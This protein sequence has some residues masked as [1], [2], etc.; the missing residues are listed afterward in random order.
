MTFS[1]KLQAAGFYHNVELRPNA[2]YVSEEKN[3]IERGEGGVCC[4]ESYRCVMHHDVLSS[5]LYTHVCSLRCVL[6]CVCFLFLLVVRVFVPV[7]LLFSPLASLS[8]TSTLGSAILFAH[9][10]CK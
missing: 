5:E 10:S 9:Y 2:G 1:K 4:C 8:V 3:D 7:V 6:V